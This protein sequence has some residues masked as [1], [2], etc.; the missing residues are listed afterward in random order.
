MT[1]RQLFITKKDIVFYLDYFKKHG[2]RTTI[3]HNRKYTNI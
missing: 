1:D 2:S 3:S